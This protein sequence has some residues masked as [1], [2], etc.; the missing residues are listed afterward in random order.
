[1]ADD[2]GVHPASSESRAADYRC[3]AIFSED[4]PPVCQRPEALSLG[5]ILNSGS[6][7]GSE[8]AGVCSAI[9]FL[10]A[11]AAQANLRA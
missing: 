9:V 2:D 10:P 11:S 5:H 6:S 3:G 4:G 1:M 7:H 8:T